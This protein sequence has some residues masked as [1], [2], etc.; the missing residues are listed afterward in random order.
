MGPP[1]GTT[2]LAA[3]MGGEEIF[4][5]FSRKVADKFKG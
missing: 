4:G 5:Y 2:R 1:L 3:Q